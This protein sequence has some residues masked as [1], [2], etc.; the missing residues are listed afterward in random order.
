M[1]SHRRI[2]RSGQLLPSILSDIYTLCGTD[3]NDKVLS[4]IT[5]YTE[6]DETAEDK[7]IRIDFGKE[8]EYE[9]YLLDK[10]CDGELVKTTSDLT[11]RMTPCSCV[12]IKKSKNFV[13]SKYDYLLFALS[14]SKIKERGDRNARDN[15]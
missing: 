1:Y 5:Y 12:L 9:I 7:E 15:Q 3:E 2:I 11:F 10:N 13:K 14:C 6:E 4:V 8:G